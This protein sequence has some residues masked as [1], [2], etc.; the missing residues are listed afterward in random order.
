MAWANLYSGVYYG[1]NTI[2]RGIKAIIYPGI[3]RPE[4]YSGLLHRII[5]GVKTAQDRLYPGIFWPGPIYTSEYIMASEG[6]NW[7]RPKYTPEY[8]LA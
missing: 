3:I 2:P 7:P 5:P 1:L 4:V 6:M 8:K